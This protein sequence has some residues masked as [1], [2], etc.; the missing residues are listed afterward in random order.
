M[1]T[2]VFV[3]QKLPEIQ[4]DASDSFECRSWSKKSQDKRWRKSSGPN[5]DLILPRYRSVFHVILSCIQPRIDLNRNISTFIGIPSSSHEMLPFPSPPFL[6]HERRNVKIDILRSPR[7]LARIN[8]ESDISRAIFSQ[9]TITNTGAIRAWHTWDI[10]RHAECASRSFSAPWSV[11]DR[12]C[13]FGSYIHDGMFR[14]RRSRT[15]CDFL[16]AV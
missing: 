12:T 16:F 3:L 14:Q 9:P 5:T 10:H 1:S 15:I 7:E 11:L 13:K 6:A 8:P 2:Q 4:V